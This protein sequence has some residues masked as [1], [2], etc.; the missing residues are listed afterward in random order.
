MDPS[1]TYK[2]GSDEA[3]DTTDEEEASNGIHSA[4]WIE[5]SSRYTELEAGDE[6]SPI[7]PAALTISPI[8]FRSGELVPSDKGSLF[9]P[10]D[11]DDTIGKYSYHLCTKEFNDSLLSSTAIIYFSGVLGFILDG[12]TFKRPG[13]YTLKLSAIIYY[14]RLYILERMLPRF[15]HSKIR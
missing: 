11:L 6:A 4:S 5:G 15:L 8:F 10:V 12:S 13:K 7:S 1:I 3:T 9:A 14:V 2:S